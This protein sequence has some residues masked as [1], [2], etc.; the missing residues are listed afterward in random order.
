MVKLATPVSVEHAAIG[1]AFTQG[2]EDGDVATAIGSAG[3]AVTAMGET[4][5]PL[6][7]G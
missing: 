1:D 5:L 6:P 2:G 7:R 4:P 3:D